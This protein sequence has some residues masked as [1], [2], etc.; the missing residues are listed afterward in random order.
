MKDERKVTVLNEP[1]TVTIMP[2]QVHSDYYFLTP[3]QVNEE[4]KEVQP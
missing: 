3:W 1:R 4:N 2:A